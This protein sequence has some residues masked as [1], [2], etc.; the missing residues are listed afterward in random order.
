MRVRNI[1]PASG[2]RQFGGGAASFLVNS[3]DAVALCVRTRL[4]LWKSEWFLNL[5]DGMDWGNSVLGKYTEAKRDIAI[6]ARILGTPGVMQ[7]VS[8]SMSLDRFSRRLTGSVT[9]STVYGQ[10]TVQGPF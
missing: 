4:A 8:Y 6:K 3:A 1:D 2:G 5:P 9:I 10:T 7:I